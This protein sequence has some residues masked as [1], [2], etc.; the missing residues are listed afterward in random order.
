MCIRDS[1]ITNAAAHGPP[2]FSTI[3]GADAATDA[4]TDT[5]TNIDA[6]ILANAAA[7]SSPNSGSVIDANTPAY[8]FP[9]SGAIVVSVA[10]AFFS[11]SHNPSNE[12]TTYELNLKEHGLKAEDNLD[13]TVV[14]T[15]LANGSR[16]GL[17]W[18]A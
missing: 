18:L 6:I 5:T 15:W 8:C 13:R 11:D 4:V 2:N 7:Y 9:K 14:R 1:T 10:C 17:G 16:V 12:P 3:A